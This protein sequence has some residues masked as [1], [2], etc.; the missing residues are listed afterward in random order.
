M[1]AAFIYSP[2]LLPF[3]TAL[4]S[5]RVIPVTIIHSNV[6]C[7]LPA[8]FPPARPSIL[9]YTK[10]A[11]CQR[12]KIVRHVVELSVAGH[13]TRE[14]RGVL[15]GCMN[16]FYSEGL[17]WPSPKAAPTLSAVFCSAPAVRSS[18]PVCRMLYS[19]SM[20]VS[21]WSSAKD[22]AKGTPKNRAEVVITQAPFPLNDRTLQA[23][24]EMELTRLEIQ[25]LVVGGTMSRKAYKRSAKVSSEGS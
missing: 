18:L 5:G 16:C 11:I 13:D 20:A 22:R 19:C 17:T 1:K 6:D 2:F 21:C 7:S 4:L 3:N 24:F 10:G 9:L 14:S 15:W 23:L 12:L 8:F 25:P